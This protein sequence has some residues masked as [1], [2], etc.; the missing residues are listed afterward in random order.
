MEAIGPVEKQPKESESEYYKRIFQKP[1]DESEEE[2][3]KRVEIIKKRVPSLSVWKNDAYKKY[4]TTS[5]QSSPTTYAETTARRTVHSGRS[6][7]PKDVSPPYRKLTTTSFPV[8]TN[9]TIR[10]LKTRHTDTG[11]LQHR[12]TTLE[13][14]QQTIPINWSQ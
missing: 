12:H 6:T 2:F 8:T 4:V 7:A 14:L 9:S 5:T 3:E 13:P 11:L 1:L 10:Y